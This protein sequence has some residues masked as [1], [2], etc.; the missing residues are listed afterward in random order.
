MT[1][2]TNHAAVT[3][4][5]YPNRTQFPVCWGRIVCYVLFYLFYLWMAWQI[6]YTHDDW[7]WGLDIGL[8]QLFYATINSR[9][10]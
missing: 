10:A 5:K 4:N 7:D 3:K 1:D 6:P 9:Y 2:C 8:T